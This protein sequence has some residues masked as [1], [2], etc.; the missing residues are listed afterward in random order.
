M[1]CE[2]EGSLWCDLDI[3]AGVQRE[4]LLQRAPLAMDRMEVGEL[5]VVHLCCVVASG[6]WQQ[7]KATASHIESDA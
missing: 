2:G 5:I 6:L 3:L 7:R 1:S 4:D